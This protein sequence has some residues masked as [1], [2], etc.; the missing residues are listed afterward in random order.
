[1]LK[2][3]ES[4]AFVIREWPDHFL[5][6]T[7]PAEHRRKGTTTL[8]PYGPYVFT[9]PLKDAVGVSIDDFPVVAV[10]DAVSISGEEYVIVAP[11]P[12]GPVPVCSD[13]IL[14]LPANPATP[15]PFPTGGVQVDLRIE[16]EVANPVG[17][18]SLVRVAVAPPG[19]TNDAVL[20]ALYHAARQ[21][22]SHATGQIPVDKRELN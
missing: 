13:D 16:V 21:V 22:A 17:T 20:Q 3:E 5:V 19:A 1:M 2:I 9:R 12:L 11:R 8:M 4:S 6:L 15:L 7:V 18:H 14:V 10:G